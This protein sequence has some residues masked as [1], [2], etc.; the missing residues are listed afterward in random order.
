MNNRDQMRAA[1]RAWQLILLKTIQS[2]PPAPVMMA[3][4][5]MME[6]DQQDFKV[7]RNW[8]EALPTMR[9]WL[10]SRKSTTLAAKGFDTILKPYEGTLDLLEDDVIF[11]RL[12]GT[13]LAVR[14]MGVEFLLHPWREMISMME[15]ARA[16]SVY[17]NAYDGYPL[18]SA[19][20]SA[21]TGSN[22]GTAGLTAAALA[23]AEKA[24]RNQTLGGDPLFVQPTHLWYHP[25][26]QATVE[27]ILDRNVVSD[28]LTSSVGVTNTNYQKYVKLPLQG[29]GSSYAAYW[30]LVD[31]TPGNVMK[32]LLW[33]EKRGSRRIRTDESELFDNRKIRHGIDY[34]STIAPGL[35]WFIWGSDGTT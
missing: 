27:A 24:M 7:T 11:D 32:P 6:V 31:L 8:F 9:K 13:E 2:D 4:Q 30:G 33:C 23:D 26:L 25:D 34:W 15:D 22:S 16:G 35:P 14:Q 19:S 12:G 5:L 21:T 1:S 17:G 18:I 20:R 29:L 10:G 3:K 28:G